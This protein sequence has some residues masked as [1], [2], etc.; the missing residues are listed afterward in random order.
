MSTTDKL[1]YLI[2]TK[3]LI[4]S[5]IID[6][7]QAISDTDTFRSYAD[8]ITEIETAP[9]DAVRDYLALE[10][11]IAGKTIPENP[12]PVT[13]QQLDSIINGHLEA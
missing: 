6:K 8:K 11:I 10:Q 7:G 1:Q 4:K 3:N 13:E 2:E 9:N 5:A 12:D